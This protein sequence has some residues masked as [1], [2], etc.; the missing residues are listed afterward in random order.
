M[1]WPAQP[2]P[3]PPIVGRSSLSWPVKRYRLL[4][5]AMMA[6][7]D[8]AQAAAYEEQALVAEHQEA[9]DQEAPTTAP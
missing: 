8:W 9:L 1:A 6:R 5:N 2:R 7:G 4:A 3:R